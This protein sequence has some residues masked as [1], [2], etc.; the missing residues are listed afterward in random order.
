MA[1]TGPPMT[2]FQLAAT[3]R[4][5]WYVAV[6][7]MILTLGPSVWVFPGQH[8]YSARATV[9][10]LWP[11]FAAISSRFDGGVPALVNYAEMVRRAL[12]DDSDQSVASASFGG[13]L[14]GA[15][16]RKGHTVVLPNLGGQWSQTYNRPVLAIEAVGATPQIAESEVQ[17]LIQEIDRVSEELQSRLDVPAEAR[18]ATSTPSAVID[19]VDGGATTSTQLRGLLALNVLGILVS[20]GAATLADP[21]LAAVSR[22]R[23]ASK[24]RHRL[25]GGSGIQHG[26]AT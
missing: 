17:R 24:P 14:V 13:S 23:S 16:V 11:G 15:G 18:V 8:V 21:L 25:A 4:R 19:V 26:R 9:E 7:G 1:Q 10:F 5:R 2:V 6:L 12:E 22:Q 20:C 3:V